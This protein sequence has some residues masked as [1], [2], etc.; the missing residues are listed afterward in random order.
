[1]EEMSMK[2]NLVEL[3]SLLGDNKGINFYYEELP[4]VIVTIGFT[5]EE[6]LDNDEEED[7]NETQLH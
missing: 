7:T 2:M 5:T 4:G 3:Y 6:E 1:M